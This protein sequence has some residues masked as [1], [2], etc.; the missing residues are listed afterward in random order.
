MSEQK[1]EK[2]QNS[3][4]DVI[5]SAQEE[6]IALQKIY[7]QA[8][9]EKSKQIDMYKDQLLRLKAEFENYRKRVDREKQEYHAWGKEDIL[10][11]LIKL[12]DV[13]E[14][15]HL[16]AS[17]TDNITSVIHGLELIHKEFDK[18]LKSEGIEVIPTLS[19]KFDP[20]MHEAIGYVECESGEDN[21]IVEE[22]QKGYRLNNRVIRPAW[23]KVSKIKEKI[24]ESKDKKNTSNNIEE[25]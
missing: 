7:K 3:C 18:F 13:L 25:K 22:V 20:Q 2:Q 5:A 24:I 23:V 1:E 9:D 4:S 19:R 14:K 6:K 17:K 16:E 15:A 8:L 11:G 21:N 10:I 12:L